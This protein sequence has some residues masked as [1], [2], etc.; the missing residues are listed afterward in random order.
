LRNNDPT[1]QFNSLVNY[2]E[3]REQEH[4]KNFNKLLVL[5][6]TPEH[7]TKQDLDRLGAFSQV[8]VTQNLWGTNGVVGS[9]TY[10]QHFPDSR[11]IYLD[12]MFKLVKS[13]NLESNL[14]IRWAGN[15]QNLHPEANEGEENWNLNTP[16]LYRIYV[17]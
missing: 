13:Q 7:F 1:T 5:A 17:A 9:S 14:L 16:D 2:L 12:L 3:R 11:V 4:S 10:H 6:L 8:R 15:L